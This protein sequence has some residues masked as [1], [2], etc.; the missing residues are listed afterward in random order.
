[1]SGKTKSMSQIKQLLQMHQQGY[2]IKTIARSIKMSKNT[3]K[4]YLQKISMMPVSI[5]EL[6]TLEDPE[7]DAKLHAGNPAY[8][9]NKR[10]DHLKSKLNYYERELQQTGV[11]KKLLWEEYRLTYPDGY[12][13]TQFCFH[14]N[15]LLLA[16]K[17]SLVLNH[18]PGEKLYVDFAGKKMTFVDK[19]TGEIYECPVFV[20]CLPYSDYSF[21]IAVRSQSVEDFIYALQTCLQYLGGV[22]QIVVP[23]N[24]KAA[25]IKA[26]RYEPEI[27]Q[28]LED[29]CN[30]YGMTVVPARVRKPQDKALVENQVK[31]IYN[32]VYAKLRH[33]RFFD[34]Y[35]LNQAIQEK[36]RD[37]NQ[38]RMQ[39]KTYCREEKFLSEEKS[40]LS[41]LPNN[42]YEIKYYRR[43]KVGHNNHVLLGQDNHYYSAPYQ[44]IGHKVTVIYTRSVVRIYAK[45][46]L[47]AAHPRE[48]AR[49]YTTVKEH[50]CSYHQ[51]YL[52]RSPQYYRQK[53]QEKSHALFLLIDALFKG[54][55]HPEQNYRTCDGLFS[56][57]RKTEQKIFNQACNIA[58]ECQ[59]YSYQHVLQIIDNLNKMPHQEEE[60]EESKSLPPHTNVR[61]KNYYSQ[62]NSQLTLNFTHDETD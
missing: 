55:R 46:E 13:Y 62:S 59:S 27:N 21:A 8:K 42:T 34:L 26:N 56:L 29:F 38:T 53:A 25:I 24:L 54:G 23:D 44:W 60:K 51:H 47:I 37:H 40:T 18:K 39:R 52:Q 28:A 9:E 31:L 50:L 2:R 5:E 48:F 3:V 32:R 36:V 35:S 16:R 19:N 12:G 30:H 1:M 61:G 6:L 7:L 22:P 58:L 17:P 41:P 57:Y 15:K 49:K 14:L 10:Y 33:M 45:G 20:A 11:T 43:Y 4:A